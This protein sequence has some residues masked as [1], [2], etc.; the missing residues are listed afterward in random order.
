MS[1]AAMVKIT[2]ERCWVGAGGDV[3]DGV[4]IPQHASRQIA[5]YIVLVGRDVI[6]PQGAFFRQ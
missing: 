2:S 3:P 4:D 1:N 5:R 6:G